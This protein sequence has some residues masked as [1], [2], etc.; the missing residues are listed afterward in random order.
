MVGDQLTLGESKQAFQTRML[1]TFMPRAAVRPGEALTFSMARDAE[2]YVAGF[3][4]QKVAE[5]FYAQVMGPVFELHDRLTRASFS[6]RW[7]DHHIDGWRLVV[8]EHIGWQGSGG[9]LRYVGDKVLPWRPVPV[10]M[11]QLICRL[12]ELDQSLDEEAAKRLQISMEHIGIRWIT[13]TVEGGRPD[14]DG[15]KPLPGQRWR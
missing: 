2:G 7:A 5:S 9:I 10:K 4:V 11:A 1:R 6:L 15:S 13:K 3:E 8:F 12:D 14:T